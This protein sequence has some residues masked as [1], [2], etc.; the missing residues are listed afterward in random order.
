MTDYIRHEKYPEVWVH[1]KS[2]TWAMTTPKYN[3]LLDTGHVCIHCGTEEEMRLAKGW[4]RNEV[5]VQ[6]A[7]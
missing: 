3:K 1:R 6:D 5:S 2:S 7:G 4:V